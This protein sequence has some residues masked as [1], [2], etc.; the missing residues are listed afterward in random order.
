MAH[1][2]EKDEK[3]ESFEKI[4][5]PIMGF[6]KNHDG[7]GFYRV[8]KTAQDYEEVEA[9]DAHLAMEKAGIKHPVKIEYVTH[10]THYILSG[11]DLIKKDSDSNKAPPKTEDPTEIETK[12]E[13]PQE[14]DDNN[15]P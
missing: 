11:E 6:A 5:L 14:S 4:S 1:K 2:S 10:S 9:N 13:S 8:Y 3:E 12:E 15:T 7:K